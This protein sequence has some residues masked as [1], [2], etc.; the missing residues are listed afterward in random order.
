LI[1]IK[2]ERPPLSLPYAAKPLGNKRTVSA[3]DEILFGS[4]PEFRAV[5]RAAGLVAATDVTLLLLGESGTGKDLL[6][7]AIHLESRR[8]AQPLVAINCA[9]LP[10]HLAES[11]LFG[12]RKGAFTGALSD[13]TGRI[14]AAHGGTLFLDEVG[15]LPLPIQAKLLRFLES[16]E[17]QG[18]GQPTPE[19]VD[20]RVIAATN[21]DLP[22]LVAAG[23]FRS[24]LYYRLHVVPL[25]LPPL[26]ERRGDLP[27]LLERLTAGLAAH[28][29]LEP[30]RYHPD[31]VAALARYSWPGNVRELRNVCERMV[32][33]FSGRTVLPTN[34]PRELQ[35]A[36]AAHAGRE[37]FTLPD[38]GISLDELEAQMIRQALDKTLGNRSRAARLLGLTRDTLLY[39]IKKY[40][41]DAA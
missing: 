31:A 7:R 25:E 26:R 16:G 3:F 15:D 12:H 37:G 35:T 21:H 38:R 17:C 28:H 8:A 5:V 22:A 13:A 30:P 9:A 36:Q 41:I 18:V 19:R 14:R 2:Y 29:G 24:D 11:E 6:A 23:R 32:V 1:E 4:A 39:R 33:L 10:E 27:G 34:L 40:A 20:V